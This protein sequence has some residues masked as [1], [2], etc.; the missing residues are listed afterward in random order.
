MWVVVCRTYCSLLEPQ[1]ADHQVITVC[2]DLSPYAAAKVLYWTLRCKIE[3]L[4]G[5]VLIH[6]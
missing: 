1:M 5:L 2:Q 4:V 6:I 3:T